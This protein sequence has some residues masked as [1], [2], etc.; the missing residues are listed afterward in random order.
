VR[1][2]AELLSADMSIPDA[3][4]SVPGILPPDTIAMIRVGAK[5]R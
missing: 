1:G 2:L 5:S 4:E 3:L